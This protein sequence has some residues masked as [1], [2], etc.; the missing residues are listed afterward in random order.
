LATLYVEQ[1]FH[2]IAADGMVKT[3][4]DSAFSS[5]T[6][7][8]QP[9]VAAVGTHHDLVVTADAGGGKST[10]LYHIAS[11]AAEWWLDEDKERNVDP[12]FGWV[13][14][15]RVR[16]GLLAGSTLTAAI[17]N[18][19][20]TELG[21][22]LDTQI[23][24]DVFLALPTPGAKWL[25][26]IDGLDEI[27]DAGHRYR[28][29]SALAK[30]VEEGHEKYR[31]LIT[32]RPLS[33]DEIGSLR[34]AG[35]VH[36][37]L[38]PFSS[39]QLTEFA[40][41]WFKAR[42]VPG[43]RETTREFVRSVEA[44]KLENVVAV[45]LLA[46]IS[47]IVFENNQGSSLPAT[48]AGLYAQFF[49]YLID[50][51]QEYYRARDKM[52]ATLEPYVN[53]R[54]LAEWLFRN[55]LRLLEE[56]A[57]QAIFRRV[58][59]RP[60]NRYDN[61]RQVLAEE[62]WRSAQLWI[63]I[64]SPHP[65]D[66]VPKW[67]EC[68]RALLIG[69]G[70]LRAVGNELE[71]SHR[72]FAEYLAGAW[73][74][75]DV[76][77]DYKLDL[78]AIWR[79]DELLS[80]DATRGSAIFAL[81]RLAEEG[82]ENDPVRPLLEWL[83]GRRAPHAIIAADLVADGLCADSYVEDAVRQ[84]LLDIAKDKR[85][86]VAAVSSLSKLPTRSKVIEA[87]RS[88]LGA[89]ELPFRSLEVARRLDYL[90]FHQDALNALEAELPKGSMR[91][92]VRVAL[93]LDDIGERVAAS[94]ELKR[95]ASQGRHLGMSVGLLVAQGLVRIGDRDSA[96][97]CARRILQL[98]HDAEYDREAQLLYVLLAH[99]G[100]EDAAAECITSDFLSWDDRALFF[101][102]RNFS[103]PAHAWRRLLTDFGLDAPK[104]FWYPAVTEGRAQSV[105][106]ELEVVAQDLLAED[107]YAVRPLASALICL[108]YRDLA[109][110]H[111]VKAACDLGNP[112]RHGVARVLAE[113]VDADECYSILASVVSDPSTTKS[114][115]LGA[116]SALLGLGFMDA[117]ALLTAAVR[118]GESGLGNLVQWIAELHAE[119]PDSSFAIEACGR[120]MSKWQELDA[121]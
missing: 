64:N 88:L 14:A 19:V 13:A 114:S 118:T 80:S 25:L 74:A 53:G 8:P 51:R 67:T 105:V 116:A 16:A 18:T 38:K 77:R 66:T 37:R 27:M 91:H 87:L 20:Q 86:A 45:P 34:D 6:K 89:S 60:V 54:E 36:Y 26:L 41:N 21:E 79:F 103:L 76:V 106:D 32:S 22:Y 104:S 1:E 44:A 9:L 110:E 52:L 12:P 115:R 3:V 28:V 17:A 99:L 29:I 112:A 84:R 97:Q 117:R 85:Y 50:V 98:S 94:E 68:L 42:N 78:K 49:L 95:L 23:N 56:L 111:L 40:Q 11:A 83:I 109:C 2:E 69:S 96:E 71:F 59:V 39:A 92:Q 55:L 73:L 119:D 43:F 70:V 5:I 61:R 82:A 7:G 62:L 46:T 75:K 107:P 81:A 101:A 108:G 48:R 121:D 93:A 100:D 120:L 15:V 57:I 113:S 35:A 90:G 72:S 10:M 31:F 30:R 47:A 4:R 102:A 65:V 33:G 24:Q 63:V 58:S